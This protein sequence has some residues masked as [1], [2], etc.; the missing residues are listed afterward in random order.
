MTH[1]T[2]KAS[3]GVGVVAALIGA[4]SLLIDYQNRQDALSERRSLIDT[5]FPDP[6]PTPS[7][8]PDRGAKSASRNT[9]R[10]FAG[11]GA[12]PICNN[13][14][15]LTASPGFV[16]DRPGG[17]AVLTIDGDTHV[18]AVHDTFQ[19]SPLCAVTVAAVG[20]TNKNYTDLEIIF[21]D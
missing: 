9:P 15:R 17:S 7:P 14:H 1:W 4:G 3:F 2:A 5:D 19:V 16:G 18:V 13:M 20:R 21:G 11:D 12:I 8:S 10:V 6:P